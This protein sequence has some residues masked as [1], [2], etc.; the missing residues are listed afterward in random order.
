MK[1]GDNGAVL[2]Q[3]YVMLV[4]LLAADIEGDRKVN[5]LK[6]FANSFS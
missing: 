5:S 6:K 1:C 2:F 4:S 3:I